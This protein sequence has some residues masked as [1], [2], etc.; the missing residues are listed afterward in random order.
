MM[1]VGSL[2]RDGTVRSGGQSP[3]SPVSPAGYH[4]SPNSMLSP[5][6]SRR[7]SS[8][9]QG[10][11]SGSPLTLPMENM[12]SVNSAYSLSQ[13]YLGEGMAS[14]AASSPSRTPF[15]SPGH[16]RS[17]SMTSVRSAYLPRDRSVERMESDGQRR[18][19]IRDRSLDRQMDRQI[20][21]EGEIP[22]RRNARDRSL[23][24][25]PYPHMGARS[26]EREH[27]FIPMG[28]SRSIDQEH[29]INFASTPN[30]S[31]SHD[32]HMH[33]RDQILLDLQ[34]QLAELNKECTILQLEND[35]YKEKLSSSMNSI[36]TFWSPELKKERAVRK[37]ECAKYALLQEQL[38]LAQAEKQVGVNLFIFLFSIFAVFGRLGFIKQLYTALGYRRL[39]ISGSNIKTINT[40]QNLIWPHWSSSSFYKIKSYVHFQ[41]HTPFI[42]QKYSTI[43]HKDFRRV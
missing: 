6:R 28:R 3:K 20:F 37:E 36:K 39:A 43:N 26:L 18:G 30:I 10:S 32:R 31:S 8:S 14:P 17:S 34:G 19:M 35:S 5:T 7:R 15:Q 41:Y 33:K 29:F 1:M 4:T 13:N 16:S 40:G 24:R 22:T 38:K 27:Q 21:R 11:R 42:F 23:D 9:N 25:D 2:G 12:Q